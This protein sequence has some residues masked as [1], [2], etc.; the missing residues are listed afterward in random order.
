MEMQMNPVRV[1][2]PISPRAEIAA[3]AWVG[4]NGP[5]PGTLAPA[6]RNHVRPEL[7]ARRLIA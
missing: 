7:I 3:A 6:I 4:A 2:G 1:G 5:S